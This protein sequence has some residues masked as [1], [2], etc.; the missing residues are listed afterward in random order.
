MDARA[1]P[2]N[3]PYFTALVSGS[4]GPS[5]ARVETV[6]EAI[7]TV[8]EQSRTLGETD[9]LPIPMPFIA[10]PSPALRREGGR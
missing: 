1:S 8:L 5:E 6:V 7:C 3:G 10:S 2:H 9:K 4:L